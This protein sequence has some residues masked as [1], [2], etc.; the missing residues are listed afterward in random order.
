M[1]RIAITTLL[2]R[3]FRMK[4]LRIEDQICRKNFWIESR[5]DFKKAHEQAPSRL[6][7]H[8]PN[9]FTTQNTLNLIREAVGIE[10]FPQKAIK[11]SERAFSICS[12]LAS[13]VTAMTGI[14]CKRIDWRILF[15]AA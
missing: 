8:F 3:L 1:K 13:A 6:V 15:K 11:T 10:W 2:L 4:R 9:G 14:F 5:K 7:I 12:R